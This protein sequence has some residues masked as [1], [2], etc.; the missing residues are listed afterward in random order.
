MNI[1]RL[2]ESLFVCLLMSNSGLVVSATVDQQRQDFLLA[3]KQ[4]ALGDDNA[5]FNLS[6]NLV[7]Y[8]LYPFLQ[9]QW[10]KNNLPQTDKIQ[11]FLNTYPDTRYAELLREKWLNYLADNARWLDFI[12]TYQN[13]DDSALECLFYW[14]NYQLGRRQFA[15][16][17]ARQLWIASDTLP[18]EC[19]SLLTAFVL[20]PLLTSDLLWQRFDLALS[21]DNKALAR[22][23]LTLLD[24]PN[25]AMAELW[26]QVHNKPTLI[27]D[28][29]WT[30]GD[31]QRGRIFAHGVERLVKS[32][33]DLAI[34]VWDA[35]KSTLPVNPNIVSQVERKLALALAKARD[36]RAFSRLD[37]VL[38]VDDEVSEWKVRAA[39]LELNWVH[40]AKALAD[41]KPDQKQQIQWQYWQARALI[42]NGKVQQG[43][44]IYQQLAND[45]SFYGFLAADAVNKPYVFTDKPITL[46]TD[47]LNNLAQQTDF[48][49]IQEFS[50]LDRKLEA[51]R[52]WW[53][54]IKKLSN[55]QLKTAAKLAQHWQWDQIAIMT[56]VK[57]DYWDDLALRFPINYLP[58]VQTNADQQGLDPSLIFGLMRQES[59]LDQY[60]QS[61]A[62]AK[63]LMQL[64]PATGQQIARTL[65]EPWSSDNRLFNPDI[66]I[67]Y[68][69][70]YYKQLLSRFDGHV[71]LAAAAYNAGPNRAVK[72][73]PHNK[74]M[75][76]DVWIETI[77]YKETR[78]YVSSVLSYTLIY[79]QRLQRNT[80]KIAQL[81]FDVRPH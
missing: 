52:Q 4:Q 6:A 22:Y 37:Q 78:K 31:Q 11:A 81:L 12:R 71:A 60:A 49:V 80:L 24:A 25:Q 72:W 43:Q 73:L 65:N 59:M 62:G 17:A 55:E 3:E 44:A 75:P 56:L 36:N 68:G 10:L 35:R 13:T 70:F 5:F 50:A 61:A 7:D 9:Y 40:I 57:A 66:N 14:A 45:R 23:V 38:A 51:K 34:T 28:E 53:F 47:E 48:K 26:L 33:L 16:E 67:K 32:N 79:Q 20:S 27:L 15:L 42:A 2:L 39:L 19:D 30:S 41:L 77:P 8:P 54:A 21:K 76:A 63:G 29:Q 64:M 46:L 18:K 74:V 69:T 1:N 58:Q